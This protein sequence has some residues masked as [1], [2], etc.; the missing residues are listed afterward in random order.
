MKMAPLEAQTAFYCFASLAGE[1]VYSV[2][3]GDPKALRDVQSTL[4]QYKKELD[5]MEPMTLDRI[6][7]SEHPERTL[8]NVT[9]YLYQNLGNQLVKIPATL[10]LGKVD[11]LATLTGMSVADVT[12]KLH[13]EMQTKTGEAHLGDS[14]M[15]GVPLGLLS[16]LNI[17]FQPP[18]SVRS[19]EE[20]KSWLTSLVADFG[21]GELQNEGVRRTVENFDDT[22]DKKNPR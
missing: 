14:L 1:L 10:L 18:S 4:R 5:A 3:G 12:A 17:P 9:D 8:Q 2:T 15:Y 11:N 16:L 19:P 13:G 22:K 20:L 21:V 7:D 6:I